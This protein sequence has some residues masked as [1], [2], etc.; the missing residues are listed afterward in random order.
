MIW[1]EVP[2]YL[3][4]GSS[5]Y[6]TRVHLSWNFLFDQLMRD[7]SL[8]NVFGKRCKCVGI[9]VINHDGLSLLHPLAMVSN[10]VRA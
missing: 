1:D 10:R 4:Q 5:L 2:S 8:L 6:G 3:E 7:S 9:A